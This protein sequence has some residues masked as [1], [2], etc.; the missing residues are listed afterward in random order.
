M[1]LTELSGFK[2]FRPTTRELLFKPGGN[3]SRAAT[4]SP[5]SRLQSRPTSILSS[6]APQLNRLKAAANLEY[7]TR[8]LTFD[9]NLKSFNSFEAKARSVEEES[10]RQSKKKKKVLPELL[11]QQSPIK[12][13]ADTQLKAQTPSKIHLPAIVSS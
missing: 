1:H 6:T 12:N 13:D 3:Y 5:R 8:Q 9:K 10:K 4:V 2:V 7:T 11:F